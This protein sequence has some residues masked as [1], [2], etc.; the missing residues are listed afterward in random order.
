MKLI[1]ADPLKAE[2]EK[3]LISICKEQE[4]RKGVIASQILMHLHDTYMRIMCKIDNIETKDAVD[5]EVIGGTIIINK[6]KM[7]E[8]LEHEQLK[9]GD[10]VKMILIKKND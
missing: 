5:A 3:D 9:A 8:Y 4:K 1:D 6:I 7:Q 10:K 2:I